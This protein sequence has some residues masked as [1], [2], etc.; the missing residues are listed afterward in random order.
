MKTIQIKCTGAGLLSHK[1]MTPFQGDLKTLSTENYEKLKKEILELGF[2]EPIS[3]WKNDGKFY[4][5]NGHQRHRVLT[6]MSDKEGYYIPAVPVNFI[7]AIDEREAKK[8]ILS[9]TSQFGEI[10]DQGL[11]E[12]MHDSDISFPEINDSFRFPEIDLDKFKEE[13]FSDKSLSVDEDDVP[14]HVEPKSKLGDIYTLGAHRLM[15]GDSTSIDAVEKLMNGEKADLV[16]TD[17]PY[18][19]GYDPNFYVSMDSEM[20]RSKN[21]HKTLAGDSGGWDYDP[22][23]L[24]EYFKDVDDIFL[25]GADYYCWSLPKKG[26][27]IAWNKIAENDKMDNMPGASFELCWSKSKHKRHIINLV[28]RGCFGH[29]KKNDGDKK[30][31]PTQKPVKLAEAFFDKWGNEKKNIVDI[32]GGSG[33]TLIACEKTNRKCFM[34][35]LDPHYCDVIVTRWCKYTNRQDVIRNGEPMTWA[36]M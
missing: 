19:F 1:E 9:L 30:V 10:T 17:P 35:E 20:K 6:Q 27:W 26:S 3:V 11:Y 21:N 13:Y 22:T 34:M 15:C 8:K 2:S 7:E 14:E 23:V 25:W 12:F 5:L 16:Y 33:S 4:L 36:A 31:H 24:L 29:N 28:W 18:G 32:Y